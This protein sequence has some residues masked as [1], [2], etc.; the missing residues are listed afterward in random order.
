MH[1]EV[2]T[3]CPQKPDLPLNGDGGDNAQRGG[4]VFNTGLCTHT[5]THKT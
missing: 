1:V 5:R 3:S 4:P 2:V